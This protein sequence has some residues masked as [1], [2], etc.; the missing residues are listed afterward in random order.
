MIA[1]RVT[2]EWDE[3]GAYLIVDT[4][5]EGR[6]LFILRDPEQAY[7]AVKAGI[8]PWLMER[9]EALAWV[10]MLADNADHSR[11]VAKGK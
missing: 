10:D 4:E 6:R 8:L 1:E 9:D 3:G 7:D 5:L 11:K 2:I